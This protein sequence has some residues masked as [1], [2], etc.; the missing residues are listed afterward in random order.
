MDAPQLIRALVGFDTISRDS[1][2]P[3][4]EFVENYLDDQ[5]IRSRRVPSPDGAKSNLVAS[6][7][8]ER[9]GGVILSGHT[10]VVPVDGQD[11][12]TD[13][14]GSSRQKAACTAVAPAT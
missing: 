11:W 2:L 10:D 13:P 4:I 3:L 7:G 14:F 8:P 9:A 12:G 1:N 5:G 6:V